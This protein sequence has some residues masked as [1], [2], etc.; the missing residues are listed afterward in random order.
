MRLLRFVV[1]TVVGSIAG[2]VGGY[3]PATM[4]QVVMMSVTPFSYSR[5]QTADTVGKLVWFATAGAIVAIFQRATGPGV[6]PRWWPVASA[7]CWAA[8]IGLATGARGSE[9]NDLRLALPAS[10]LLSLLAGGMLVL[11]RRTAPPPVRSDAGVARAPSRFSGFRIGV[12]AVPAYLIFVGVGHTVLAQIMSAQATGPRDGQAFSGT[13]VLGLMFV[14]LGLFALPV[15]LG[16]ERGLGAIVRAAMV[17]LVI[18][19]AVVGY[20][21]SRG[22]ELG[23][24]AGERHCIVEQGREICPAGDGTYIKDARPDLLVILLAVIGAYA[25]AHLLGRSAAVRLAAVAGLLLASCDTASMTSAGPTP[26]GC[27]NLMEWSLSPTACRAVRD[28][29]A[30]T[31]TPDRTRFALNGP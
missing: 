13:F 21:A 4:S 14:V 17:G 7:A 15:A 2:L 16:R 5:F 9:N 20:T 25:L 22:Y 19:V 23:G 28:P 6:L 12:L 26:F 1:L 3:I 18:A 11:R 24:V 8:L 10:A 29:A 31:L 27:M 30:A